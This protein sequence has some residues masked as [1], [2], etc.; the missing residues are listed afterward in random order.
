MKSDKVTKS[1]KN[2]K[3][4]I[5]T[6]PGKSISLSCSR[7]TSN[8]KSIRASREEKLNI[9]KLNRDSSELRFK[10]EISA[11][12]QKIIENLLVRNFFY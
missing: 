11:N 3:V 2:T 12:S 10:P 1:N 4:K 9:E 8:T 5:P 6:T 7:D